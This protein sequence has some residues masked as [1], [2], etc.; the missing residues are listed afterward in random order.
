MDAITKTL[1]VWNTSQKCLS[2]E[3][4][5]SIPVMFIQKKYEFN[6]YLTYF[7]NC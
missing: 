7:K 4:Q 6:E 3:N 5:T 2:M 1:Y